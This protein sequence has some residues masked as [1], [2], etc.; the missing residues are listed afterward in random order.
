MA[1]EHLSS[2]FIDL[3][4][5]SP[6]EVVEAMWEG[7][8]AAVASVRPAIGAIAAAVEAAVVALGDRGRLVYV[9]AGTSGRI[10]IQ[11]GAELTPTFGLSL[12]HIYVATGQYALTI[13]D[14]I[15]HEALQRSR[16]L[17]VGMSCHVAC[18]FTAAKKSACHYCSRSSSI[19]QYNT[20]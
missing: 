7:H 19:D 17:A 11:D 10:A 1:T 15:G 3:D 5:W 16:C 13:E 6:A 2:R 20:T 18:F 12:I 9:G 4:A 8:I 14:A